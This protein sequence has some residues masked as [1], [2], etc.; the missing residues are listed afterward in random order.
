MAA[1][2]LQHYLRG[3]TYAARNLSRQSNAS[4]K[5][6]DDV[7]TATAVQQEDV[8]GHWFD[9]NIDISHDISLDKAIALDLVPSDGCYVQSADEFW[10][11]IC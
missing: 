9:V 8:R 11:Y 6:L 4:G 10:K 7:I 2:G 5:T 3:I 1:H